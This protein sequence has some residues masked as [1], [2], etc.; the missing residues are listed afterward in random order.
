MRRPKVDM[1][2]EHD[3]CALAASDLLN[4][5][6]EVFLVRDDDVV[7]AEREQLV[8]FC[9]GPSGGNRNSTRPGKTVCDSS[10]DGLP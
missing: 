9:S 2:I 8:L 5:R 7:G 6:N 4:A 10:A 3:A 1:G